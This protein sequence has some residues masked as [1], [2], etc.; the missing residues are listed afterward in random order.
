MKLTYP[1]LA[2]SIVAILFSTAAM[3]HSYLNIPSMF[4]A[5]S[6]RY[7]NSPLLY[8]LTAISLIDFAALGLSIFAVKDSYF[9]VSSTIYA[10]EEVLARM[11]RV[12]SMISASFASAAII[13]ILIALASAA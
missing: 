9:E 3:I 13:M 10:H 8:Q 1:A 4:I 12:I 6:P 5:Y 11:R 2:L 7:A